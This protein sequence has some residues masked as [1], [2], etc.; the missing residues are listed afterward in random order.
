ME[1]G[2]KQNSFHVQKHIV[3]IAMCYNPVLARDKPLGAPA[4]VKRVYSDVSYLFPVY[5]VPPSV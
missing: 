5:V 4:Y 3:A 1:H 2:L